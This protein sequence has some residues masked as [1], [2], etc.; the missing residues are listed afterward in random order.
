MLR[1]AAFFALA[2]LL[3]LGLGALPIVGPFFRA[4][5]CLGIWIAAM[6]LSWGVT[7]WGERA[8]R[9]R[10]DRSTIRQLGEVENPSNLGKIGSLYLAQGR[11]RRA[12]EPLERATEGEP[13]V[14]EWHYRLGQARLALR[15]VEEA[16]AALRAAVALDEEHA[17]GGA[18]LRLAEALSRSGEEAQALEALA[19]F[20]RNHGPN[21]E[22]AFRRGKALARLGR[23]DEARAAWREVGELASRAV[24]YQRREGFGWQLRAWLAGLF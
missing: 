5:G 10:R 18:Q 20:E 8:V 4:T 22:S 6:L 9:M 16:V 17:Y 3:A 19:V 11:P 24:R 2:Y 13:D 12:L 23:R 21:P 1:L 14:A 15:R 7:W